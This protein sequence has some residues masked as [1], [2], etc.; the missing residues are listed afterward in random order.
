MSTA[1]SRPA[2][3]GERDVVS[4]PSHGPIRRVVTT[5]TAAG[6]SAVLEDAVFGQLRRIDALP[7][8][9]FVDLWSVADAPADNTAEFPRDGDAEV[10]APPKGGHILR[11]LEIE[12]DPP[13]QEPASVTH[14]TETLD[15][16]VILSGEIVCVLDTEEVLLRAGDVLVQ[17]G[18]QHAWSN[19]GSVC[20]RMV[21]VL[22][23]ALP[24]P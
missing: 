8:I 15:H 3:S 11:F 10:P 17:R 6:A 18:T 1:G 24:L 20:C 21:A 23:D 5:R 9:H 13:G 12:P 4:L 7:T 22:S 19:R 14:V 2:S 16:V